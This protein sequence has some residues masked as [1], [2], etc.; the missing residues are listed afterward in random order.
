MPDTRPRRVKG[1]TAPSTAGHERCGVVFVGRHRVNQHALTM[2]AHLPRHNERMVILTDIAATH[3][4][5]VA[6]LAYFILR[7]AFLCVCPLILL[8]FVS[9]C[10]YT[11]RKFVVH[12]NY[13]TVT[14]QFLAFRHLLQNGLACSV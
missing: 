6:L 14:I 1:G 2:D 13:V 3:P 5:T 7:S 8:L 10:L 9:A 4:G 12:E 11:S